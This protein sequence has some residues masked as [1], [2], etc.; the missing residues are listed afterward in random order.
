MKVITWL[1]DVEDQA[2]QTVRTIANPCYSQHQPG[3]V[4]GFIHNQGANV[5][6]SGG[7]GGRAVAFFQQYGIEP[8]TA[9]AGT[10]RQTMEQ[11]LSGQLPGTAPCPE[12]IEH[13]QR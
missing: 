13:G 9:A 8:V 7:M 11:F 1:V 5:M 12:S 4:P 10:V 6:L 2:V 3:Q